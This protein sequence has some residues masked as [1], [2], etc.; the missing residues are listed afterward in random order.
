M[1]DITPDVRRALDAGT[2]EAVTLVEALVVDHGKLFR[3]LAPDAGTT[4]FAAMD[5]TMEGK[6]TSRMR[7]SGKILFDTFGLAQ[8]YDRFVSHRSDTARGWAAALVGYAPGLTLAERL[9]LIAVLAD[10]PNA[11]TREWAWMAV[12]PHI[13]ADLDEAI[14]QLSR[15]TEEASPNLRRFATE[16]T[17]PRGVWCAHIPSLKENPGRALPLLEPLRAD[18]SKYVQDSVGNW[19][20]DA[21]KSQPDCVLELCRDWL[22]DSPAKATERICRRAVRSMT[23]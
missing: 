15:W 3:T 13:S 9:S 19:L 22:E 18:D 8:G 2:L 5:R 11:G 14:K 20:N 1:S 17:R 23:V 16:S 10:D 12:R 21:S 4:A 6:I 7:D